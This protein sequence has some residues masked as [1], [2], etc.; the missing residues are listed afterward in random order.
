MGSRGTPTAD[1]IKRL[2]SSSD[3]VHKRISRIIVSRKL[4]QIAKYVW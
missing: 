2:L 3:N 4:D 1:K